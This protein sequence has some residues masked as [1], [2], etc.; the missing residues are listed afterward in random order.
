LF[1]VECVNHI[2]KKFNK[3]IKLLSVSHFST[4]FL[5]MLTKSFMGL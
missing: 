2:T 1:E 4:S 3:C 5:R